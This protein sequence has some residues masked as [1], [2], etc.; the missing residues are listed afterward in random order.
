MIWKYLVGK[1]DVRNENPKEKPELKQT[2]K[3]GFFVEDI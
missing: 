2:N 3:Q 1:N